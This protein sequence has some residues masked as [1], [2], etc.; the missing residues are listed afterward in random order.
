MTDFNEMFNEQEINNIIEDNVFRLMLLSDVDNILPALYIGL[1]MSD[2][3]FFKNYY[4]VRYG[5]EYKNKADLSII[6]EEQDRL[7]AKL[8]NL[9]QRTR[10]EGISFEELIAYTEALLDHKSIDRG[11]KLYQFKY[12][13]DLAVARA[14]ALENKKDG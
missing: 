10:T 1:T 7:L 14:K 6:V 4:L 11:I 3:I 5:R 2:D 13:F 8:R 12:Q 9:P